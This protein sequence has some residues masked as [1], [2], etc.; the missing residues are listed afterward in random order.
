MR[1][2]ELA[3]LTLFVAGC[4]VSG[5]PQATHPLMESRGLVF[6]TREG[7]VNTETMRARL[8]DAL[9]SMGVPWTTSSSTWP[10]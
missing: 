10:R 4:A 9:K 8:D 5:P 6:L 1:R 2:I 7:C 3:A